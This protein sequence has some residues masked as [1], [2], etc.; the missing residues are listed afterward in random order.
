MNAYELGIIDGMTKTASEVDKAIKDL[1]DA[2][3]EAASGLGSGLKDLRARGQKVVANINKPKPP[4]PTKALGLGALGIG[5]MA[6][7]AM[8]LKRR[9]QKLQQPPKPKRY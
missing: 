4:I 9:Q 2:V 7:G 6:I 3:G 1:N 5:T 8:A